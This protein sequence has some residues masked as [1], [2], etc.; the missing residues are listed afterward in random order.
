MGNDLLNDL[1][2][3]TCLLMTS[4]F[5]T[6]ITNNYSNISLIFVYQIDN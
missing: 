3:V 5:I 4:V 1:I 6:F 2:S